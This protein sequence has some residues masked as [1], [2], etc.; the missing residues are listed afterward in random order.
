MCSDLLGAHTAL[1]WP[2]CPCH[3]PLSP[4]IWSPCSLGVSPADHAVTVI[5]DW[6]TAGLLVAQASHATPCHS[7]SFVVDT[8]WGHQGQY[9]ASASPGVS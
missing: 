3:V 1:H 4:L 6:D 5:S 2:Q 9:G 8:G 7:V